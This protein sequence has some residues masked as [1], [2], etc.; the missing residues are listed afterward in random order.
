MGRF[1]NCLIIFCIFLSLVT[2][3]LIKSYD[4]DPYTSMPFYQQMLARIDSIENQ[5]TD[6]GMLM[7]GWAKSPIL[8]PVKVP[9]ASYGI[10]DNYESV[11][12]TIFARAFAFD[13]GISQATLVTIDLLIFPPAIYQYLE[14]SLGASY[15][16]TLF[17][18]A[19]HTHNGPGGW[20][21][22]PAARFIAGSYSHEYVR[23]LGNTIIQLI[24]EAH[25]NRQP[26]G[27]SYYETSH[28][29]NIANRIVRDDT[30]DNTIRYTVITGQQNRKAILVS[31]GAH[32]NCISHKINQ[33]SADYPGE[34][35]YEL[36]HRGYDM[37]AFIAGSVG[38]MTNNCHGLT[39]YECTGHIGK[40]IAHKILD[41]PH[42]HKS[43]PDTLRIRSG[44]ID[45]LLKE[46]SPRI[47]KDWALRPWIFRQLLG[48]Q[49]LFI[50]YLKLGDI[51]LIGTPCDFSGV[52]A[53][54]IYQQNSPLPFIITS[55]N[56]SYAGY[57]TPL[58]YDHL[59]KNET[60][61]MNWLG[62]D[63]GTYFKTLINHLLSR[64]YTSDKP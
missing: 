47:T 38:S 22:G 11:H 27:I 61:E 25:A 10:R 31:Y 45:L 6:K 30:T 46:T 39:D 43:S 50:S 58:R 56:G 63:N 21:K 32:A 57:I 29:E 12:D 23:H 60:R 18:S 28:P 7:A 42:R 33:I 15:M 1:I 17:L 14:D 49:S 34:L 35:C 19:T 44:N 41:A 64:L 48:S 20:L 3:S 13:N 54:E 40:A 37:A 59:E 9:I 55:F 5:T 26:A 8:P 24:N 36:E 16:K 4:Q 62:Y 51:S 52:I 2:I 53:S